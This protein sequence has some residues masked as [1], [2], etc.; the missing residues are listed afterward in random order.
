M[1]GR[2]PGA[3]NVDE[4]WRNVRDG[5][6]SV[7][8]F[9]EQELA[10]V[11]LDRK[12]M[13]SPN[14]VPVAGVLEDID[15]FDALFFGFNA[16]DAEIMD[17]QQRMFLECA[18]ESLENAAYNP[19]AY[20]G[21]IGVFAGMAMSSYL[22]QLYNNA[23]RLGSASDFQIQ[24]LNDKDHL[25]THTS[26]KLN[27]RGPSVAVQ[28][29]CSTSL[30][31]VVMAVRSL[32]SYE[33]DMALAGGVTIAVPQRRG[34]TYQT[35]GI[36]SPD[37][38][39]R[40]FDAAAR[41]TVGSSAVGVVVLKRL[42]EAL[43]DGDHIRAV[44][45]GAAINNDGSLKA[46][47]TAPSVDGQ[48]RVISMAH[49]LAGLN[50]ET[51]S[52]V[53][54]HGT[55]TPLGD[56]IELAALTEAFR[57]GTDKRNFCAI[58]SV[59][60]N[61]GH[62]D[63]AAGIAGLIKTVLALENRKIPA[64]L[65]YRE[66][67]PEIDFA[68]SPFYVA[69]HLIDW[70]VDGYPRRAGVS[71]FGIGGTN[72]HCVLEEA[73]ARGEGGPGRSH[74]LL[75]LSAKTGT[76][77]ERQTE[78]LATYLRANG[79]ACLADVAYC[80]QTGRK[81]FNHRRMLVCEAGDTARAA[82]LL[83]GRDP[84][85]VFSA[86]EEPRERP[87]AFLFPGQGSQYVNMGRE[88]YDSEGV[89]R[90]Q[91][92]YCARLLDPSLGVDIRQVIYPR[93]EQRERAVEMLRQ[94]AFT[95][96]ALFSIEYALA[97]QWMEWGIAPQAM[98]GHSIG[99]FTAACLAGVFSLEDALAL[100]AIRGV[101]MESM[102]Q[103]AMLSLPVGEREA[104]AFTSADI[105]LAA[106]NAPALSV[107]SGPRED[108][109]RIAARLAQRGLA[110]RLLQTSHAFHSPM[111]DAAVAPFIEQ[112]KARR[113]NPP[114]LPYLSN[115]T[116]SWITAEQ[117]TNPTYW[118]RH[119]RYT[120]R[121]G[122]GLQTLLQDPGWV[123]LE[124]GP[125]QTL[126]TLARQQA[127][128]SGAVVAATQRGSQETTPD[129]AFLM[130]TIGKLW[131]HG[132]GLDWGRMYGSERRSRLPLP[133]YPFERQRYW[134]GPTE[135]AAGAA[136]TYAGTSMKRSISD[137]FFAPLWLPAAEPGPATD[138]A[139]EPQRWLLFA[140]ESGLANSMAAELARDG[141]DVY[142]VRAG[143]ICNLGE[144]SATIRPGE[145]ED[146][147]RLLEMLRG[148]GRWPEVIAHLWMHTVEDPPDELNWLSN[149]LDRSFYSLL[150]LAQALGKHEP[151]EAML[152]A[153]ISNR[154]HAPGE[155]APLCPVKATLLGPCKV[156][157]QEYPTIRC[158][159]VDVGTAEPL[160][161]AAAQLIAEI[162]GGLRDP[163]VALRDGWR[164]V[165]TFEPVRL[166]ENVEQPVRIKQ[167]GVYLIT[168]GLGGIGLTLAGRLARD[169]Q[170][171]LVLIGRTPLPDRA[172]WSA[173][174]EQH[175][176][177][178]P[179][180]FQIARVLEME[181][182]GTQVMTAS[183][184]VASIEQMAEV[185]RRAGERF[186]RIDGV[187]HAAG[188]AGGG[189]IQLKARDVAAR[190]LA[191]KV[192][193]TLVLAELLRGVPLDFFAIC[194]SQ[195]AV[196]GG[197]GQ[198]DYCAANNFEDAFAQA[199]TICSGTF[200]VS[201]NWDA[202]RDV[203]MAVNTEL[204]PDMRL[205]RA[206]SL[207]TAIAPSE[208]GDAFTRVLASSLP[209]VVVAT[210]DFQTAIEN[211]GSRGAATALAPE[212]FEQPAASATHHPR[213]GLV[214]P[215]VAPATETER[216]LA[217]LWE[218]LLGVSPVGVRD[219]FFEL[220]GHSLLAVQ[221]I[222]Q[223]RESMQ[224]DISIQKLFDA[225]TVAQLAKVVDAGSASDFPADEE[226]LA[227]LLDQ[228]ESLSDEDVR[229]LLAD[230]PPDSGAKRK[231]A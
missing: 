120:V 169:A 225:A 50:P 218:T 32:L 24:I 175:G 154:L 142:A 48:A 124:T 69:D 224:V 2:F 63:S 41:G 36:S 149:Y 43:A 18:W 148:R 163:M 27:L 61:V 229:Q 91:I 176:A 141:R 85:H 135:A 104:E 59:K 118:G 131:L 166:E 105:T 129:T 49:T 115:L 5:V 138:A 182:A 42:S 75:L 92:D 57:L 20:C 113:L 15:M 89:F 206:E 46:G 217:Q 80:Y 64:S 22:F 196:L 30:V 122:D 223:M 108:L 198:V 153:V 6:E 143:E 195:A 137:W 155:P 60:S 72:A 33:C 136:G 156:I 146:Y 167:K 202:W 165:Q 116:G 181:E 221:L 40:P 103:G 180:A 70:R 152:L 34:Y 73:P 95:Q 58:G 23:S 102:P 56:P 10:S 200:T 51:I 44:I 130:N 101:L 62:C 53:E 173:W 213:P 125:G 94:T 209:Q 168:G 29:A 90:E 177:E 157:P 151:G 100:V 86:L 96:P 19:E 170:A 97:R 185:I 111:M 13:R 76:A 183:A 194:S 204:P 117:A 68:A 164:W 83:E 132:V 26:Y 184:D 123:L 199:Q 14:F 133:T 219:N 88:L 203:G 81:H 38:H 99:E 79:D 222:S 78:N 87:V 191:P 112:V 126:S 1:S 231:G 127:G 186:G 214:T 172:G 197:F 187:I 171:C 205:S 3:R 211:A 158:S 98:I 147:D 210:T 37:G 193:G 17:P 119:L 121:F 192:Q 215:Y 190:V 11:G 82:E 179:I 66:P 178:D 226:T 160:D 230:R 9:S 7:T 109:D 35:G 28:T 31:A 207:R 145:R 8:R 174:I 144:R 55:A 45:R 74:V 189:M 25:T 212:Q 140:D 107:L 128:A 65:Y 12:T 71:S 4:Y 67:N 208:G 159:S 93:T 84:Q 150:Y 21:S 54:A 114:Q 106:V 16:R 216:H 161:R 52:Y 227:R 110:T 228:V 201:I 77:L 188:V 39:C 134:I 47:Y 139:I 220:G 162:S